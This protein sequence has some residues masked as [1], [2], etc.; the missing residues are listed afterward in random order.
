MAFGPVAGAA[1]PETLSGRT[2]PEGRRLNPSKTAPSPA[3]SPSHLTETEVG[4]W[5]TKPRDARTHGQRSAARPRAATAAAAAGSPV[6]QP[7]GVWV[8]RCAGR[9]GRGE[10]A[11]ASGGR[12][13]TTETG[14]CFSR[15]S[16][17]P[18]AGP[19]RARRV[20]PPPQDRGPGAR[21]APTRRSGYNPLADGTALRSG[22]HL[23]A[24][25]DFCVIDL[26]ANLC[27]NGFNFCE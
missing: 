2:V 4:K 5:H 23:F 24:K 21:P 3:R 8:G 11:A 9:A 12:A 14:G 15:H 13:T 27:A 16:P 1:R 22:A 7:R 19:C 26:P 25:V 17:A 6:T 20:P 18:W 10:G